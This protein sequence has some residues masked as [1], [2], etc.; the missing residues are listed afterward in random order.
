MRSLVLNR[1]WEIL[2]A[3]KRMKHP[4]VSNSSRHSFVNIVS[5]N[6]PCKQHLVSLRVTDHYFQIIKIISTYL[7][8]K[9]KR[10]NSNTST[11]Y[12]ARSSKLSCHSSYY[13]EF[14]CFGY[15][16]RRQRT[17]PRFEC[18]LDLDIKTKHLG[19]EIINLHN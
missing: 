8:P 13:T 19:K 16:R 12:C 9:K 6:G 14:P 18:F 17:C 11:V 2:L 3:N 5:K 1:D 10:K 15:C 7:I 4:S